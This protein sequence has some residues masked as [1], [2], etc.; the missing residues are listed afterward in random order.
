MSDSKLRE[1]FGNSGN[2]IILDKFSWSKSTKLLLNHVKTNF[3]ENKTYI[4]SFNE[5][6]H[7]ITSLDTGG[8]K[9]LIRLARCENSD[10]RYR[11]S[12]I[13]YQN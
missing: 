10:N 9:M 7:V 3:M 4:K 8:A 6:V 13:L 12:I 11:H 1:K 5:V 2:K